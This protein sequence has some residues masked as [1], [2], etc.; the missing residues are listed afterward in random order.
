MM[1]FFHGVGCVPGEC[2]I[3][4][5]P[6]V[7]SVIYAARTVSL[8]LHK[9]VKPKLDELE[10]LQ[11]VSKVDVPTDWVNS[12]P[13]VEKRDG[14]IRICLNPRDLNIAIKREHYRIPVLDDVLA[15][16]NGKTRFSF[17]DMKDGFYQLK[18][19]EP[20]RLL[21]TFNTPFGRYCMNCLAFG[22]GC[23]PERF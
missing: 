15:K 18:L 17:I 6:S 12:L 8:A 19:D 22:I 20:S 1:I 5:D 3:T 2:N 11:I 13:V 9:K 16:L 4:V 23:A 21:C 7:T 10:S 14:S